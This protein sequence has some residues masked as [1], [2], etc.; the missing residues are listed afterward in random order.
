M[1]IFDV[2][3]NIRR[4]FLHI[5]KI[6]R[7]IHSEDFAKAY[8]KAT[9]KELEELHPF[10]EKMDKK[11]IIMWMK[12]ILKTDYE[13]YNIKEL[14]EVARKLNIQHYYSLPRDS[15]LSEIY[16]S[17]NRDKSY[18]DFDFNEPDV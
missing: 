18:D 12:R 1:S 15:L 13:T 9:K 5:Q 17:V 14:R 10:I 11:C 16:K 2:K 3:M 7:L 4:T 8:E 6:Y